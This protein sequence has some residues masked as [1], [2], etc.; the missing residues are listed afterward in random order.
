[1]RENKTLA[2]IIGMMVAGGLGLGAWLVMSYFGYTAALDQYQTASNSVAA[3]KGAK[4]YPSEDHVL[5]REEAVSEYE[6][7]VSK[8]GTVLLALQQPVKPLTDTEFQARLKTRINETRQAADGKTKLPKEFAFGFDKYN[9][10]LPRSGEAATQLGDY[11]GAV[12]AITNMFIESGVASID[13]FERTSLAVES[14]APAPKPEPPKEVKKA[15][16]KTR[17]TKGAKAAAK[18]PAPP[19]EITKVVERRT[20]T[21]TMTT[22][23]GALQTLMNS[24]ASPSKMVHFTIVRQLRIDNEK[25][26]GPVRG[27]LKLPPAPTPP[28]PTGGGE[29]GATPPAPEGGTAKPGETPAPAPEKPRVI[30]PVKPGPVDALAVFGEE[31]LKVYMEI[32]IVRFLE[33]KK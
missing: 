13:T 27:S 3:L 15:V 9:K 26:E 5:A 11:L 29:A 17:T 8:L 19:K 16:S 23:Q 22:D 32:D 18:A 21:L 20:V 14:D 4:V 7:A 12:D 33:P 1:M 24:L 25:Q 30:E 6:A 28:E 2:A 10:T 31:K